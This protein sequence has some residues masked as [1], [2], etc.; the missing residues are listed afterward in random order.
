M[1]FGTKEFFAILSLVVLG[2]VSVSLGTAELSFEVLYL[3]RIPRT[4]SCILAG[5]SLA[6]SGLIIQ[7]LVRNK[8]VEPGTTGATESAMLGV[9][10]AT[11]FAPSASIFIKMVFAVICSLIG[12]FGFLSL[13]RTLPND[14]PLLIPLV[15]LIYA[16]IIGAGVTFIAYQ[17]DLLQYLGVWMSGEFSGI[18]S[19]RYEILWFAAIAALIAYMSA[20]Q[21]TVIGLGESTTVNLG[22]NYRHVML[23]GIATVATVSGIVVVTIGILPFVGLVVPNVVS[24]IFGDNL[25][26]TL[27][28]VAFLGGVLVLTSDIIGRIVRFPYEVPAGT[29]FG[30]V[31]AAVFLYLL[32]RKPAHG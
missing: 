23:I 3:S 30:I 16:G 13:A 2:L 12:T 11:L 5:A 18:L 24:R 1:S 21:L 22:L 15:G 8:F 19:G 10:I 26:Q 6:V 17:G 27:P 4:L 25:K 29:I 28:I 32:L 31:G 9:L 20:N 14:Q 7:I